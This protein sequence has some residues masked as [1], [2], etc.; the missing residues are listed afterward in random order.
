MQ[1]YREKTVLIFFYSCCFI[2]NS[3]CQ[4]P[5]HGGNLRVVIIRHAEKPLNGDNLSCQGLNRSLK[6]PAVLVSK[7]GIPGYT[8]T[9]SLGL[10]VSTKYARMFQTVIPLAV[11][12]NLVINSRFKERDSAGLVADIIGKDGTVLLVWEHRAIPSIVRALGMHDFN[13][14]W[15]DYDYDS[16]WI[17]TFTKGIATISFDK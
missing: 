16:I 15:D 5:S 11:K 10:G 4:P 1:T 17:I 6:L 12:Y 8:Y 14:T 13:L 9:P 3:H 7:F 2:C